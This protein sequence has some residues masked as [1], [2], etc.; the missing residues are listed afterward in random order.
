MGLTKLELEITHL[1][2]SRFVNL[3]KSTP[4]KE[5]V[6]KFKEPEVIDA[7]V[8]K[9]VLV[10]I[11]SEGKMSYVPK[12]LAFHYGGDAEILRNGR[13]GLE[14]ILHVLQNLFTLEEEGKH[15]TPADIEAHARK[16]YDTV[17]PE[18]LKIGLYLVREFNV[19]GMCGTNAEITDINFLTVDERI[20]TLKNISQEWDN[21]VE[22]L[23][24]YLETDQPSLDKSHFGRG[25]L[26]FFDAEGFNRS[27][28]AVDQLAATKDVLDR[29][30]GIPQAFISYSWDS[31]EHK[32]W[33]VDFATR[34]QRDGVSVT[35]DK[36]HLHRGR[37]KALFMETSVANSDFV[38]LICTPQYASRANERKGGVGY[39]A[40]VITGELADKIDSQKF[41]PILRE[42]DF[43][44]AFPVWIK[45]RLGVDLRN[46]PYPEDEYE[47]LLRVLHR[48]PLAP[49]PL[50]TKPVW[51]KPT[52]MAT[53]TENAQTASNEVLNKV[54]ALIQQ[55]ERLPELRP[56]LRIEKWGPPDISGDWME[57]LQRGF[58]LH[59]SGRETALGVTIQTFKIQC[60][61]FA[62]P[63]TSNDP[64]VAA[65]D[66]GKDAFAL[67]YV[68]YQ[69]PFMKFRLDSLLTEAYQDAGEAD[70]TV[71]VILG[72][73]DAHG[74]YYQ[75]E[76][77][78]VFAP[79][80]A[81]IRFGT[82][83]Y[84]LVSTK[85]NWGENTMAN[86]FVEARPKGRPEGS[87]I[88][89]YVVEDHA[90][91]EL[92]TFRTQ[93]EAIDWAKANGHH[94]LV[95][96]VRHLNNKKIP[97]HWRSA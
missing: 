16:M 58:H 81:R 72:Y 30:E 37:D 25:P 24:R 51:S 54:P 52:S 77:S 47:D 45:T 64:A 66:A 18:Q 34:L 17:Q 19:I 84:K 87:A 50:G 74:R 91:H 9:S 60:G 38:I 48:E 94:P 57:Q 73:R 11:D 43:D 42:G 7:L 23:S 93:K 49:P 78:L 20:V 40:M 63:V 59:N 96:R 32:Q 10:R 97:D 70:Q 35:L 29:H 76:Q 65:V 79:R 21:R 92:G 12:L 1:V 95:A 27:V 88:H 82:P 62:V 68:S 75:T 39:E 2:L 53:Q 61:T 80:L 6:V 4:R 85:T 44:A 13:T 41:I 71:I 5:L 83:L 26:Q 31:P 67:V 22:I 69:S 33:V 15:L 56:E 36:W 86:V 46:T 89:D 14:I 90:D 8:T 55:E 28:D 3:K